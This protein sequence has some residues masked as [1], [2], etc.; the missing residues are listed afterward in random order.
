MRTL[1]ASEARNRFDELIE[2]VQH[3]P[4]QI[5][6]HNRVVS[7]MLSIQDYEAMRAFYANRLRDT[8]KQCADEAIAKG[9]TEKQLK[10]LLIDEDLA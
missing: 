4:I 2:Q 6:R 7:V 5:T 3:E 9:F 10:R 1:T 8:L